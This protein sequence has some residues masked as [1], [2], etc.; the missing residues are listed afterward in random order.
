MKLNSKYKPIKQLFLLIVVLMSQS[1][2]AIEKSSSMLFNSDKTQIISANF[3]AGSVS[4]LNREN[5]DIE[6]EVT[7]GRDIRRIALTQDEQLL[8]ATDT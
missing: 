4:L 3:D 6:K 5:G 7:I 1:V 8:L 2:F